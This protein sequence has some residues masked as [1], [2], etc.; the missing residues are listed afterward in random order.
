MKIIRTLLRSLYIILN[1]IEMTIFGILTVPLYVLSLI[2]KIPYVIFYHARKHRILLGFGFLLVTMYVIGNEQAHIMLNIS[3]AEVI[4][5]IIN[6][7][8][9]K[10]ILSES[11]K[12]I[13]NLYKTEPG[14]LFAAVIALLC[15]VLVF[16][17]FATYFYRFF[18][19]IKDV[20][21]SMLIRMKDNTNYYFDEIRKSFN[22]IT[23]GSEKEI[24]QREIQE[25]KEKY[26]PFG[27]QT[28]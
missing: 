17:I 26:G 21:E 11:F 24:F 7:G 10:M 6:G 25:F 5:R 12:A 14:E 23:Y 8:Y 27:K 19:E 16:C 13:V 18:E 28:V 15:V 4:T 9:S 3:L 2:A 22:V 1:F 20:I